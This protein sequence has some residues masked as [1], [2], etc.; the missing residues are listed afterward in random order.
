MNYFEPKSAAERYAKG[1]P[2]FHYQVIEKVRAYIKPYILFNK[3]IDIG[4]GTGLSTIALKEIARKIVGIDPSAEMIALAPKD[5]KIEY[6]VAPA[7]CIPVR[8][9]DFD[10]MTLCSVFHWIQ[11]DQFFVEANRILCPESW[12][13]IY[14]NYFFAQ[15]I[16]N[17]GFQAWYREK[18]LP[19]YPS[20][21]RN[22]AARNMEEFNFEGIS[23]IHKEEYE[24]VVK[25]SIEKLINYLITQSN[26]IFAVEK[27]GQSI[28]TIY[29]WLLNE[30]K[31]F[32]INLTE[33]SFIFGGPII[34][35]RKQ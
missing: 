15:M 6:Y 11:Q 10:L 26:I 16:E 9:Q 13:V 29:N 18:Y 8:D 24:N 35:L 5:P 27:E 28:S 20:P 21:P 4:C 2:Y 12:I 7:D 32:F 14:D 23:F 33:A 25:F 31:P 19:K 22:R 17:D 34:Y 30:I 1:R 3:A